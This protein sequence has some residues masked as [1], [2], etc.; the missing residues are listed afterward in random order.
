SQGADPSRRSLAT[1]ALEHT[2]DDTIV[3]NPSNAGATLTV[4]THGASSA[5]QSFV[6]PA[7][8]WHIVNGGFRYRRPS[9]GSGAITSLRLTRTGMG[10]LRLKMR[11]SGR[12]GPIALVP[13]NP[14]TGACVRLDVRN[15][16]SYHVLFE[17]GEIRRNDGSAFIVRKPPSEGV[18]PGTPPPGN[19]TTTTV[20][21]GKTTTTVPAHT[22][23]TAATSTTSTTAPSEIQCCKPDGSAGGSAIDCFLEP[24]TACGSDGGENRGVGSCSP[25][26][27]NGPATT[28]TTI[29]ALGPRTFTLANGAEPAGS[30]F[31][32]A[33]GANNG[34]DAESA[35]TFVGSVPIVG[36]AP[37]A[38]G[39]APLSLAS[40]ALI[41]FQAA[42]GCPIC[43]PLRA[44]ASG[45]KVDC[46][47]G[48]PVGVTFTQNSNGAAADSPPVVAL[49]Q[50]APGG[51][52]DGYLTFTADF[53]QC[54]ATSCP[55]VLGP[56]DCLSPAKPNF[57]A[58][59]TGSGA[60]TT[61][62]ATATVTNAKQ[63]GTPTLTP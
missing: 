56:N 39:V 13:P 26:T 38:N 36:G 2:S 33:T 49:E 42:D 35:N 46:D 7:S 22:T 3:G 27:C 55:N 17:S 23:T 34:F 50:G 14:G 19:T 52:G 5:N 16:D 30:H 29:P 51:P 31:T 60:A 1:V 61:G 8:G 40:D 21:G 47:G 54:S 25:N 6:L 37:D 41:G 4:F 24:P 63:G 10:V 32:I 12:V 11:A 43:L 57:A 44:A 15:G 18:C 9:D 20:P 45:G 62:A 48:T 58:G 53:V 28:T 59:R